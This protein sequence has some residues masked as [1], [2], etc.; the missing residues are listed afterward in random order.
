MSG[1]KR[2]PR[3]GATY[4]STSDGPNRSELYDDVGSLPDLCTHIRLQVETACPTIEWHDRYSWFL[5][6]DVLSAVDDSR[7]SDR[8]HLVVA[9]HLLACG[10]PYADSFPIPGRSMNGQ[11]MPLAA[12]RDQS[13]LKDNYE[14]SIELRRLFCA[15][16][17]GSKTNIFKRQ[18]PNSGGAAREL[19]DALRTAI[20]AEGY[21]EKRI[22]GYAE[23]LSNEQAAKP[24]AAPEGEPQHSDANQAQ[25]QVH[26]WRRPNSI[27]KVVAVVVAV[28]ALVV[29]GIYLGTNRLTTTATGQ[30]PLVPPGPSTTTAS[31]SPAALPP[32]FRDSPDHVCLNPDPPTE[33]SVRPDICVIAWCEGDVLNLDGRVNRENVFIK[34]RPGI[35]NKSPDPLDLSIE[36]TSAVRLLVMEAGMPGSWNPPPM[37][38]AA[39]DRPIR[40]EWKGNWFW[41]IA[42][43]LP[44]EHIPIVQSPEDGQ[45]RYARFATFWDAGVIAGGGSYYRSVLQRSADP[46]DVLQEADLVFEIPRR[47]DIYGIAI[48]K[49]SSPTDV[50]AVSEAGEGA[51][52][53]PPSRVPASF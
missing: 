20:N 3:A 32:T 43:N 4:S 9:K 35:L 25:S 31:S 8:P 41:A 26:W 45:S 44:T 51:K 42:P 24:V 10:G 5:I 11:P 48:V 1:Y 13:G 16:I 6:R 53:W 7:V 12:V 47:S 14:Q 19:L 38:A 21:L 18:E 15:R 52:L 23:R 30:G 29:G 2:V 34:I 17:L 49:R 28:L 22:A 46:L 36:G 50:L 40:V 33:A 37:T 27:P 39:G